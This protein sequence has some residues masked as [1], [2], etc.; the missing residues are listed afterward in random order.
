[1]PKQ[2]QAERI[3][4]LEKQ[5]ADYHLQSVALLRANRDLEAVR[6]TALAMI[7]VA[8]EHL[9]ADGEHPM[10]SQL[11]A[12]RQMLDGTMERAS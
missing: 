8:V 4:D 2:T 9:C 7:N 3:E 11:V 12:A 6:M 5:V 10:R 1:M